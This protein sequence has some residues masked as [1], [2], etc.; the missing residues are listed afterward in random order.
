MAE[1][2]VL[3]RIETEPALSIHVEPGELL[4][5]ESTSTAAADLSD[6]T[7]PKSSLYVKTIQYISSRTI[8]EA[9]DRVKEGMKKKIRRPYPQCSKHRP[10]ESAYRLEV[11]IMTHL[12]K[13][14]CSCGYS[15]TNRDVTRRHQRKTA[16]CAREDCVYEV[17]LRR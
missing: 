8:E 10:F 6:Y 2:Q 7:I 15:S 1:R 17:C 4:E 16:Q 3:H 12:T 5:E 9:K 14:Y 11:H 13:F